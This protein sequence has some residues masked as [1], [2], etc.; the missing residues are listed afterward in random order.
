MKNYKNIFTSLIC[1]LCFLFFVFDFCQAATLYL[2]PFTAEYR[3]GE[4]FLQEVRIDLEPGENINVV[5][6]NLQYPADLLEVKD[7]SFGNSILNVIPEKPKISTVSCESYGSC[8]LLSFG[9]G[10]IGGYTGRIPGDPGL[11]NLVAKIIFRVIPREVS[12]KSAEIFFQENSR[13][14]LNDGFGTPAKLTTKS[15]TIEI[16]FPYSE[17]EEKEDEWKKE[18]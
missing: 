8:G 9:G 3:V 2:S 7:I 17:F 14:L 18:L 6:I 10:I 13:V 4:T 5:E 11:S 1:V 15:S 16:R 12:R